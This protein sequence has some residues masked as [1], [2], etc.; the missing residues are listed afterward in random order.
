MSYWTYITGVITVAPMG[1]TQPEKRYVLDTVLSHLPVVTGSEGDMKI[2]VVQK[3]GYNCSTSHNEFGEPLWYRRTAD[4]DG[5]MR[6][7][8]EY[9]LVLEADLRDRTYENTLKEFNKWINR[10][11][12]RVYVHD[13]VV[14]L[15]GCS[16]K[17]NI[18]KSMII[19]DA[20]PYND[21]AERPSSYE[22]L[23]GG[24]PAWAEYL[25]W[26]RR[27]ETQYPML[28]EYKYYNNPKND[29]EVE[30]RMEYNRS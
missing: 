18:K 10:L 19:S 25:L 29:A 30:R 12:K 20:K 5:W 2:H 3:D 24:E 7:Q 28:L 16:V 15:S 11:A 23:S 14:R 13:V 21:M 8:D 6:T 9:L 22:K 4:N 17:D 1:E 26:D 27:K